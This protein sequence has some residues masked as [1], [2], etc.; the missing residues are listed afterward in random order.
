[1]D[2]EKFWDLLAWIG[3]GITIMYLIFKAFGIINSPLTIDIV[4]IMG[5]SIFIGRHIQKVEHISKNVINL[6]KKN[7]NLENKFSNLENNFSNLENKFIAFE[8]KF[9]SKFEIIDKRLI[10]LEKKVKV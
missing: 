5:A 1:M 3:F 7:N 4:T 8:N 9:E 2:W 6:N 10:I